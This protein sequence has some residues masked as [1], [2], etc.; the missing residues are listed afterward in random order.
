MS[1]AD[2]ERRFAEAELENSER[3]ILDRLLYGNTFVDVMGRRIDPRSVS[4]SIRDRAEPF[5]DI[6]D[7]NEKP[8]DGM[9]DNPPSPAGPVNSGD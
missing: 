6:I 8:S 4:P 3:L 2:E 5:K 1:L 7:R 9:R